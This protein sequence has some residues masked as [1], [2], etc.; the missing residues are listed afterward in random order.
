MSV[1]VGLKMIVTG[2][3]AAVGLNGE[4]LLT[5]QLGANDLHR[6][7]IPVCEL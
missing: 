3:G 2:K 4:F 7:E 1:R 5:A 6:A